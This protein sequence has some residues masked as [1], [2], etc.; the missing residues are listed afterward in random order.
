MHH[1]LLGSAV[2]VFCVVDGWGSEQLKFNSGT[3]YINAWVLEADHVVFNH[4]QTYGKNIASPNT[5]N[6]GNDYNIDEHITFVQVKISK[7][8]HVQ[9]LYMFL[10]MKIL[11]SKVFLENDLDFLCFKACMIVDSFSFSLKNPSYELLRICF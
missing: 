7:Q 6:L 2:S 4:Q 10:K 11:F 9:E 8:L 3:V 5:V 1:V